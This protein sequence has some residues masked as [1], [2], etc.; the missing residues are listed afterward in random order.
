MPG[1][2][3][4]PDPSANLNSRH[5]PL[6]I[7]DQPHKLFRIHWSSKRFLFFGSKRR[8]LRFD[9]PNKKYGVMYC[10]SSCPGAFIETLGGV[11]LFCTISHAELSPR[12]MAVIA[13]SRS[14]RLVSLQ[15]PGLLSLGLQDEQISTGINYRQ[16]Q[17]WA[18]AFYHHPDN[19]DGIYYRARHDGTRWSIALFDRAQ[20]ALD[21]G[22]TY[23]ESLALSTGKL[24]AE[25]LIAYCLR[26]VP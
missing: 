20:A 13:L 22:R 18:Q 3:P 1:P 12:S 6:L 19:P 9:D 26:V 23:S 25:I 4:I 17:K 16:S 11:S 14:L 15:Q 2:P 24:R 10:S 21:V 7:F 8:E 5:L